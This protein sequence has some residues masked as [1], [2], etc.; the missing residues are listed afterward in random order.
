VHSD[1]RAAREATLDRPANRAL[2]AR[3]PAGRDVRELRGRVELVGL[4]FELAEVDSKSNGHRSARAIPR[5]RRA[6]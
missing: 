4:V 5:P 3:V 1:L 6:S 2:V